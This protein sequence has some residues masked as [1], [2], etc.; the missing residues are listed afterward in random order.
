MRTFGKS[1]S[2]SNCNR[3]SQSIEAKKKEIHRV[4]IVV[5]AQNKQNCMSKTN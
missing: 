2:V 4:F 1:T 5:F 3:H